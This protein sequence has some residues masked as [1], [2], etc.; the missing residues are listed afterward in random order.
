M[1]NKKLIIIFISFLLI[2][3]LSAQTKTT[4]KL[5]LIE[6]FLPFGLTEKVAVNFPKIGMALSGGGA[7]SISQ[8]GVL[9]AFEEKNIPIEF[10]VGTSMGSVVGGLYSAGYSFSDLDSLL[11]KTD[12]GSFFSTQ[13]SSRN[14]LFVDQKITEDRAI[15]SFRMDGLKPLI[16]TSISSGQ[17]AANF[18]NLAAINAPLQAEE[19]YNNLRFKFRAISSDLVSGKEIIIDK[20]PLGLAMRAS[21]SVTLLL[22]PV[23][24]DTLLLV[25]GGLVSNIPS[26][27]VRN[28][29]ADIVVAVDASSPLYSEEELN[30]PWTIADQ[31]VSIPMKILNDR[32][33]EEA[34]F[35]IQPKLDKRK[36]SD[37]TDLSEVVAQGYNSALPMIEKIKKMFERKFKSSLDIPE[38]IF[39]HLILNDNPTEFEKS[40]Y[41][42][43]IRK[44]S[45]SNKELLFN[46]SNRFSEGDL[47]DASIEIEE[48]N[49]KSILSILTNYNPIISTIEISGAS[50]LNQ[51]MAFKILAPLIENPFCP[52]RTLTAALDVIRKFKSYGYSLARIEK[53]SFDENTHV[54]LL[55]LSEGLISK[56]V[57]EGN[58][59]TKEKIITREF[60]LYTGDY[61]KYDLAEKGLTNLRSTNLFD[62]IDLIVVP[63]GDENE[64]KIKVVEK[65]SSVIRFGMRI[66]NEYQTQLSL[67]VRDEN[68][69]GTGTEIGATISGG[70]R[71]RIYS[72]EQKANRVFDSYLT[73]KVRAFHEFNDINVY[74]DDPI[75]DDNSFSRS[76]TGEYRQ[77]FYG[78]SF[79][80]GTQVGR[81]GNLFVEARYQRDEIKSKFDYTGPIYKTDISSLRFSLSI[82]SQN[83]Y[84][85]PTEG[86]L[87]KG[88]YET[89]QTALG[90]DIGYTKFSFDYK[91]YFSLNSKTNTWGIR[92]MIGY[93][94][95]TLPLTEEFSLGGQNS[96]FG[97]R[98]YEF[99]GRQIFLASLEHRY[100]LP[101]K[102][103]FDAYVRVRY[104][105]GSIW[106]E[107][108]Q[109]R[110]K[111]LR[112][113]IG[114]SLSFNTPIGPADFSAGKSFYF[115]NTL[116]NNAI[117][118]GPT[119]FYFTIGYYY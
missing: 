67:D 86:F 99:R 19:S 28:L 98:N 50:P 46:L 104:D 102:L 17:R 112:H 53:V 111:D 83:D 52:R 6:K 35:V 15:V 64:I 77:L 94:D 37:F 57:V 9:L 85:F 58:N 34:D 48:L 74:T 63:L 18:L 109:I 117:V 113:G 2:S 110:F 14:D 11:Q 76:K 100:K 81:F 3:S 43:L 96:F 71:S 4:L 61:F 89:A 23:K 66:D 97:L 105:L 106:G 87:V 101:I 119:F 21:S 8:L 45:V 80:I 88:V 82:D 95:K 59:K 107:R 68:F 30:F 1:I 51:E 49:G 93:A 44:D 47:K 25:D 92:A 56:I 62:Q 70:I 103:F 91:N 75:T 90:G 12:W 38:K 27:E 115:K 54:L 79:G 40:F 65:I 16:P 72:L 31:L 78:G 41:S 33:L 42:N 84:P 36:N 24:V 13:Q 7:R 114:A 69:N 108:E 22:P 60:P 10:I 29:G 118:W 73:Y 20:G 55:K 116:S 39:T 5:D 26:R 32:Q